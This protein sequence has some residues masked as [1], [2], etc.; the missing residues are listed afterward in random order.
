MTAIQLV[1]EGGV[2]SP[3]FDAK[4]ANATEIKSYPVPDKQIEKVTGQ[5]FSGVLF[6]LTLKFN[7]SAELTVFP[8]SGIRA[9]YD[10]EIPPGHAIVGIYGRIHDNYIRSLGFIVMEQ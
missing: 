5:K 9:N 3:L 4:D 1:F 10:C 2:E 7:D 6:R 8:E